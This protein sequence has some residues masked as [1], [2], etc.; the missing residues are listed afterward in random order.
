MFKIMGTIQSL[1][2]SLG[3]PLGLLLLSALILELYNLVNN[4]LPSEQPAHQSAFIRGS[5]YSL[6]QWPKIITT[7]TNRFLEVFRDFVSNFQV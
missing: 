6:Y 2:D 1:L 4:I 3:V 5:I 7:L